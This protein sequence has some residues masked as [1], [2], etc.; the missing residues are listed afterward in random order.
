MKKLITMIAL[1]AIGFGSVYAHSAVAAVKTMQT[2]TTKKKVKT[3]RDSTKKKD[4]TMMK[5]R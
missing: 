2:D 1:T 3:K 4:S 5:H